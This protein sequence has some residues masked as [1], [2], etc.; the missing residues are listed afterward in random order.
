M[1]LRHATTKARVDSIM[2]A[3]ILCAK[4]RTKQRVVW[5]HVPSRTPWAYL[6]ML[7]KHCWRVEDVVILEV[8]VPRAWLR[9]SAAKG[10]WR[11]VKDIPPERIV[12]QRTF[13][14]D[15]QSPAFNRGE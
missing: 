8:K 2:R 1:I 12:N 11:C 4:S 3:G 15:S 6:H 14:D 13:A 5:L 9:R 10:L 7:G